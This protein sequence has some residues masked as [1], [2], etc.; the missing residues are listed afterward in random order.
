[1][2]YL[3]Y[4]FENNMNEIQTKIAELRSQRAKIDIQIQVLE[5]LLGE[6]LIENDI[7]L[8][9]QDLGSFS[10]KKTVVRTKKSSGPKYTK[11]PDGTVTVT[12]WTP[13]VVDRDR[14][15]AQQQQLKDYKIENIRTPGY[16]GKA[17]VHTIGG[18]MAGTFIDGEGV[19]I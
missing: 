15:A 11:N 19:D 12:G 5:E 16:N 1:M 8:E 17:R 10:P 18:P 4:I 14:N 9:G 13:G 6:G 2:L 7:E 3:I